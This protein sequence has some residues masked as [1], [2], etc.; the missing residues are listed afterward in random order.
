MLSVIKCPLC[1]KEEPFLTFNIHLPQCLI[2]FSV[3]RNVVPYC[4]CAQCRGTTTHPGHSLEMY[5]RMTSPA[6]LISSTIVGANVNNAG[7]PASEEGSS[8][9]ISKSPLTM[10]K[11]PATGSSSPFPSF[12]STVSVPPLLHSDLEPFNKLSGKKCLVCGAVKSRKSIIYPIVKI[13]LYREIM[14]CKKQH[15]TSHCDSEQII[16]A[17]EHIIKEIQSNGDHA[18]QFFGL[19]SEGEECDGP[20]LTN[21]SSVLQKD[22]PSRICEGYSTTAKSAHKCSKPADGLLCIDENINSSSTTTRCIFCKPKHALCYMLKYYGCQGKNAG[23][24]KRTP[25]CGPNVPVTRNQDDDDISDDAVNDDVSI[26][27]SL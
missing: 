13:G 18:V 1:N 14:I 3:S 17:L 27:T 15:L 24:P 9:M 16:I 12:H 4:T 6:A 11:R 22:V 25:S 7:F 23:R 20:S 8:S 26:H 2:H 10:R 5:Q 19:D 21:D